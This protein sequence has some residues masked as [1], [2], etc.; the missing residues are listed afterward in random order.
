[1]SLINIRYD[2]GVTVSHVS[3]L[4]RGFLSSEI[5]EMPTPTDLD[6]AERAHVMWP[7]S[8]ETRSA[9]LWM[10]HQS[11]H[12]IAYTAF[13][14]FYRESC[15]VRGSEHSR[16]R[17]DQNLSCVDANQAYQEPSTPRQNK[18][19]EPPISLCLVDWLCALY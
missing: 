16:C 12:G 8:S 17:P 13:F 9:L 19:P 10:S 6:Q 7:G 4:L 5:D 2:E 11:A 18:D 3:R 14:F 1:M 15:V